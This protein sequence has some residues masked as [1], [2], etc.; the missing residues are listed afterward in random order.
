MKQ[1]AIDWL[2]E[3]WPKLETDLPQWLIDQARE[4]EREQIVGAYR[5]GTI[6]KEKQKRMIFE[7]FKNGLN[8][9]DKFVVCYPDP[10][11]YYEINY[12][13]SPHRPYRPYRPVR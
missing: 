4:K 5:S 3:Q 8:D 10:E 13:P 9:K 6:D 1:T 12:G 11:L 7:A 2:L